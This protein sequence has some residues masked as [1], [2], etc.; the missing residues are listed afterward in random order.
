MAPSAPTLAEIVPSAGPTSGGTTVTLTGTNLTGATEVTFAGT[1]ATNV[2][3]VDA[4]T[5][6]ADTPA[7]AV[8]PVDVVVTTPNGS[9]TLADG[10]TY[11]T[12]VEL[13][14]LLPASGSA[15]GG[16][17]FILTGV[18]LT[19]ATGVL[20]DGVA[21]TSVNVVNSTT[22]TGVT[23]AHA[24]GA[25]DVT[26][27]TPNGDATLVN[28][29]QYLVTAVGQPSGGGII[30]V[31]NGG[32]NNLIAATADQAVAVPWS[33]TSSF[34]LAQSITDGASNT[35]AIVAAVGSAGGA[36]YAA[37]VCN[38][39]EVDSQGNTPCQAGNACYNDWFLPAGIN[40]TATGQL[41][42]LFVNRTAIGG[43]TAGL[44]WSSTE[45]DIAAAWTM[46]F[47]VGA[48]LVTTKTMSANVRCVRAFTP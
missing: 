48:D 27:L 11:E 7:H 44:Y 34:V 24:A 8:G 1:A 4:T 46:Q 13:T 42:G 22:V 35:A 18:N 12:V 16:T 30:A 23:P 19:G 40:P 39:Y 21:A 14:A 29:Y 17:G 45:F 26:I 31:L 43:F 32:L 3:V 20:F 5:V 37:L 15:S 36:P 9:A 25:V 47:A 10:F 2:T 6:T 41:H 28:G 38:D 33:P